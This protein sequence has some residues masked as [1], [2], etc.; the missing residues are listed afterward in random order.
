MTI[1]FYYL[2]VSPTGKTCPLP[3]TCTKACACHQDLPDPE[4]LQSRTP[5]H[6]TLVAGA[7]T[8]PKHHQSAGAK[9]Q[10]P[11]RETW[12]VGENLNG[13]WA[14]GVE[15]DLAYHLTPWAANAVV[16]DGTSPLKILAVGTQEE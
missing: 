13:P 9:A 16:P 3:T 14:A 5:H 6:G 10:T 7:Q 2:Q 1:T 8:L 12:E 4:C 11:T 15:L